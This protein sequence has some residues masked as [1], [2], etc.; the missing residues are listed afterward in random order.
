MPETDVDDT[1]QRLSSALNQGGV[2]WL[3][4][5]VSAAVQEGR[6]QEKVKVQRPR[7]RLP[8]HPVED[9]ILAFLENL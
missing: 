8:L 6:G 1:L 5:E 4:R 9:E 2:G 3:V 7:G